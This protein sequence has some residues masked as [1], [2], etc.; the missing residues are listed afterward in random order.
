MT[1]DLTAEYKVTKNF[2]AMAG[3][4]N[5]FNE[6]YYTR[7]RGDGIDPGYGLNFYV[8]GSVQF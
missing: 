2:T 6:S 1:W 7:V 3:L 8:G 4:N 5:V